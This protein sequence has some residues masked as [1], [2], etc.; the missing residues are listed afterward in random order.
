MSWLYA[1]MAGGIFGAC[2]GLALAYPA[3]RLKGGG[4]D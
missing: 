1:V 2:L 4:D 3:A